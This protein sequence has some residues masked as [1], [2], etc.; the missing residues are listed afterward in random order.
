MKKVS[1]I[2]FFQKN[3]GSRYQRLNEV[4]NVGRHDNP[5]ALPT[6]HVQLVWLENDGVHV[7]SGALAFEELRNLVAELARAAEYT[8]SCGP[9]TQPAPP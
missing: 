9:W 8:A 2:P 1:G 5:A 6:G 7:A 3:D 4:Y